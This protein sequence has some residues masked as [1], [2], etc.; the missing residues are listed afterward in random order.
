[1]PFDTRQH[2]G[3][4]PALAPA[5]AVHGPRH[6]RPLVAGVDRKVAVLALA[7]AVA[8]VAGLA[9]NLVQTQNQARDS[10][11]DAIQR[12]AGLTADV[13]ASAFVNSRPAAAARKEFGGDPEELRRAVQK[14][15]GT[16]GAQRVTVLD[17]GGRV[18]AS[19]GRGEDPSPTARADVALAL[20]GKAS[21]SD[22]FPDGRG[23]KLV[24][25]A[26]PFP[27]PSGRRVLLVASPI[28]VVEG[29]TRGFFATPSAFRATEGYLIDGSGRTLSATRRGAR[30]HGPVL[31]AVRRGEIGKRGKRTYVSGSVPSS[32]WRVVLSVPNSALYKSVDG[33]TAKAA[34]LL[35]GAFVA[36]I[37]ALLVLGLLAARGARRLAAANRIADA[38]SELA[39]E[40]LHDPLT[41][42]ANRALFA[43]RAEQAVIA[44]RR[45]GRWVAV[46]FMDIDHYKLI[47]D[48]LGHEVGD[49][50]LREVARRLARSV[51]GADTVSRFGGD[52]FVVLCDDLPHGPAAIPA[53]ERIRAGLQGPVDVGE[54]S[55]P[56]SF[57]IGVAIGG[58]DADRTAGDLL[59]DAD[60]AM[61]RAKELGRDRVEIFDTDLQRHAL[62]RLDTEVALRC[63]VARD[64]L[65]LQYQPIVDLTTQRVCGVEA[66]VRW[67]RPGSEALIHPG[68]FIGVAEDIGVIG[69]IGEWVLKTAVAEVGGWVSSGL[70]GPEFVLSVNVSSRQ[71]GDPAFPPQVAAA[72][73]GWERPA[74]RLWLEITETAVVQDPGL[75]EPGLEDL[76]ALGVR[77]ALD[78]FGAGY[79]SLGKLAR[80]LPISILKLDRSFVFGMS[81]R[82]DHEI[83]AAAAALA[84]AL[85]LSSV[86]E[87]VESAEQAL[88][89]TGVGF[90]YAQGFYFGAP[91]DADETV[92]RLGGGRFTTRRTQTLHG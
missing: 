79:S 29:F 45:R 49:E 76:H 86:A 57:S 19:A 24:E 87:G 83:V 26:V 37:V 81:D 64:E 33:A 40:R 72:L 55:V 41:G 5:V 80:S 70:V 27:S 42:L 89:V 65:T 1:M 53:V 9:W 75:S 28:S 22:A 13:I 84:N 46:V 63:A 77:L 32:R 69:A 48:S 88:A 11:D 73:L 21:L 31:A 51:R 91:A 17:A 71:L 38:A 10:L 56:V 58:G 90:R 78:D 43:A 50:V 36:A 30:V 35:F 20:S 59:A 82:R 52:E 3:P 7:V 4:D 60:A 54:R 85:E 15:N 39:H 67:R 68:A 66:L 74:D 44:A 25:L 34:W 18:L 2:G 61:Y 6:A 14:A 16:R 8:L 23:G 92:R 62:I 47:N 12:R